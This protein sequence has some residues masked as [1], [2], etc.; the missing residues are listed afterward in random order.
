M[1]TV[2]GGGDARVMLIMGKRK[3]VRDEK[4]EFSYFVCVYVCVAFQ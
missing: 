3:L 4:N 1:Y 2:S